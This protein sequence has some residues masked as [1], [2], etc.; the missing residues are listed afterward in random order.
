MHHLSISTVYIAGDFDRDK[1]IVDQILAWSKV[2]WKPFKFHDTHEIQQSSDESLPCSIKESLT[3]RLK[4]SDVFVLI[5][6]DQTDSST[7]GS[8]QYCE[9][10]DNR[11]YYH[12]GKSVTSK[13]YIHFKCRRTVELNLRIVVIYPPTNIEK[14][15][16]PKEVRYLAKHLPTYIFQY[17][18]I[19]RWNEKQISQEIMRQ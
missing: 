14:E 11:G 17:G 5:V 7:Q 9:S 13:S 8:Y 19:V 10:Y 15:K 16:C 18:S 1:E 4:Q 12:R 2:L 3:Y 6:G